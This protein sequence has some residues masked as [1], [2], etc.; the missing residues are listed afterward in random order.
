[1]IG[2]IAVLVVVGLAASFAGGAYVCYRFLTTQGWRPG[3]DTASASAQIKLDAVEAA[4][5]I[6]AASWQAERAMYDEAL[7]RDDPEER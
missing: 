1:M 3:S 5:R 7:R 2:F 6:A 4:A